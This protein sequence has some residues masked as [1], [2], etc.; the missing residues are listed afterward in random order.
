LGDDA[1][2]DAA[3]IAFGDGIRVVPHIDKADVILALDSDFLGCNEG[4]VEAVRAFSSR[5]RVEKPG[6]KMTRLYVA[7]NRFSVTGVRDDHRLR[8][9]ASKVGAFIAELAHAV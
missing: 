2:R 7:D 1:A 6:D 3:K 5:R 8:L 9:Q 4:G